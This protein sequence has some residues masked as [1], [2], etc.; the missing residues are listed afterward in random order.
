MNIVT[1][2]TALLASSAL[3]H[4]IRRNEINV[5]DKSFNAIEH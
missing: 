2:Q 3:E 1:N 5:D 4:H